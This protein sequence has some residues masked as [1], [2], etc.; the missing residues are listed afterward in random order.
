MT[1]VSTNPDAKRHLPVAPVKP[2]T[3]TTIADELSV[4]KANVDDAIELFH[5]EDPDEREQGEAML[6]SIVEHESDLRAG[7]NRI[8]SSAAAD[9]SFA[10]GLNGRI[11]NL[12]EQVAQMKR[13]QN[14]FKR[15]A[16]RKRVYAC[17]LLNDHFPDE[18]THP[19]PW[20]NVGTLYAKPAV[21]NADGSKLR[22]SDIPDDYQWLISKEEKTTTVKVI[23]EVK[24]LRGLANGDYFPFAKLKEN[25]T[26][27]Y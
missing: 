19:T 7:C 2:Q 22:L 17:S 16:Q 27:F 4:L 9:E 25:S 18:K 14:R 13:Q 26:R 1:I 24:I 3:A 23:D 8:F 12:L 11:E 6:A 10:A 21:V 20:G 5:S 15:R